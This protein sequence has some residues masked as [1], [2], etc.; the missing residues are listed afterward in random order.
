M[1]LL[2]L[3]CSNRNHRA[4]IKH[5]RHVAEAQQEASMIE[6]EEPYNTRAAKRRKKTADFVLQPWGNKCTDD[7]VFIAY[8]GIKQHI[9]LGWMQVSLKEFSHLRL[10]PL[11][12]AHVDYISTNQNRAGEGIGKT[13]MTVMEG[14]MKKKHCDFIELMP[15]PGVIGF[16]TKLGYVLEFVKVN[17]YTKWLK[18]TRA[19]STR[20]L[21]LYYEQLKIKDQEL[22]EN[23]EADEQEAFQPIYDQFTE[24]EKEMYLAMQG[25]DESTRIAMIITYEESGHDIREV[26]TMLT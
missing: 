13:M 26:K 12:I 17:Y 14:V 22:S 8:E 18:D 23:M 19:D 11:R 20:M 10:T 5:F 24:E 9:I 21:E 7:Y 1:K 15:L 3:K 2:I 16:Y 4:I 25:D 6:E